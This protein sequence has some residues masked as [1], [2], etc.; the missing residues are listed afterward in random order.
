M[1]TPFQ[2]YSESGGLLRVSMND[3]KVLLP[4]SKEI[5][6]GTQGLNGCTCVVILGPAA[7]LLAHIAPLPGSTAEWERASIE[8]RHRATS[9]H[10]RGFLEAIEM[11]VRPN[12]RHFPSSATAW[13][14]FA[15]D[16]EQRVLQSIR[17]Q[18]R[19]RLSSMGL[20]M[21]EAFYNELSPDKVH[22]PKGELVGVRHSNGPGLYLER[23]QLWPKKQE[24][25]TSSL[26]GTSSDRPAPSSSMPQ[27][28]GPERTAKRTESSYWAWSG[29]QQ[30]WAFI[31][32]GEGQQPQN[33][34]PESRGVARVFCTDDQTWKEFDF[35][36]RRWTGK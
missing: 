29:A 25:T 14:I 12:A 16:P 11:L 36:R 28:Q 2:H 10:H 19:T 3:V 15:V 17:N 21:Y 9:D 1:A 7:I 6:I 34:W 30:R 22:P 5:A 26:A 8:A 27:S 33:K 24:S 31:I 20:S 23:T 35:D 13:G 32:Q 18:I 4:D